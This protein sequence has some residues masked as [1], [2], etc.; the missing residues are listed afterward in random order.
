MGNFMAGG[1]EGALKLQKNRKL[2]EGSHPEA[3]LS[4]QAVN[5]SITNYYSSV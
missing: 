5:D 1:F 2:R 4:G 3:V